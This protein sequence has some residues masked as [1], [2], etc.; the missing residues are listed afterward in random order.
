MNDLKAQEVKKPSA[1]RNAKDTVFADLFSDPKYLLMLYKD[2]HPEDTAATESDLSISSIRKVLSNDIYNDLSFRVRSDKLL[3]LVEAQ[4]TFTCNVLPRMLFYLSA[5]W[6]EHVTE[7][8]QDIYGSK[9]IEL[10]DAEFYV[11]FSGDRAMKPRMLSFATVFP[12]TGI[13]LDFEVKALYGE[14]DGLIIDQY[15][16]FCKVLT[17]QI[18]EKGR[19]LQAI[20]ETI[21]LC[22]DMNVLKEYLQAR[23]KEVI[24]IMEFLFDQEYQDKL[25][26][27]KAMAIG[28]QNGEQRGEQNGKL[29]TLFE[30][31]KMGV[32]PL[33]AAALNANLSESVFVSEMNRYFAEVQ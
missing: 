27:D 9:L 12:K 24:T 2:L 25:R 28:F 23:E 6:K 29:K 15:V 19:N 17:R 10:P 31:T 8:K 13:K 7:T 30:L 33:R 26:Y 3:I 1:K 16:A 21:R 4:S 5:L 18:K 20:R 32:I 11:I 14:N 22:T